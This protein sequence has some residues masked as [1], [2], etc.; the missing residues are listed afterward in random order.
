MSTRDFL[1]YI[2]TGGAWGRLY[3]TYIIAIWFI[4]LHPELAKLI[5]F[6]FF[7]F[8]RSRSSNSHRA[9]M[10]AWPRKSRS[11]SGSTSGSTSDSSVTSM[12]WLHLFQLF[13][14]SNYVFEKNLFF[15]ASQS[16]H[17][18]V[19]SKLI[20]INFRFCWCLWVL[21]SDEWVLWIFVIVSFP[22]VYR[23]GNS[24]HEVIYRCSSEMVNHQTATASQCEQGHAKWWWSSVISRTDCWVFL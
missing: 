22:T 12:L 3:H 23:S 13:R 17:V 4:T 1:S 11:T 20:Q 2:I 16:C 6:Q 15:A 21:M 5:C 8:L 14:H 19:T 18:W 24:F 9:A 7:M 10:L